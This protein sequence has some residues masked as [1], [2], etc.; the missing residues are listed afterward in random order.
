MFILKITSTTL[1]TRVGGKT[2]NSVPTTWSV[3]FA[4][5]E[6]VFGLYSVECNCCRITFK[7]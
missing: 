4:A 3:L 1:A 2:F 5:K 6:E 7:F